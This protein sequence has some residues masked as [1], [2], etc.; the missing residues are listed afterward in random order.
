MD[1]TEVKQGVNKD[2][3]QRFSDGTVLELWR[4]KCHFTDE[5][6]AL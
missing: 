1:P 2:A 5:S 6:E 3:V 4:S